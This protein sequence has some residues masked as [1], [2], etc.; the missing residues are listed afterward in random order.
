[1]FFIGAYF[2]IKIRIHSYALTAD[3]GVIKLIKSIIEVTGASLNDSQIQLEL[4][5]SR[6]I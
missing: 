1:M 4:V 6:N 3:G 5:N 2:I